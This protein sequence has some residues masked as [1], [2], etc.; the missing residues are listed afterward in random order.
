[1]LRDT[2]RDPWGG[3]WGHGTGMGQTGAVGMAQRGHTF[4]EILAHY[5]HGITLEQ[6]WE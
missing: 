1:M 3:G 5:Y 2:P 6:R 4:R